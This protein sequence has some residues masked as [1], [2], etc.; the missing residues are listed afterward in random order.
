MRGDDPL[1]QR[2][3]HRRTERGFVAFWMAMVLVV[4]LGICAFAIDLLHTYVVGQEAQNAADAAALGGVVVLPGDPS[5]G[6]ANA[7]AIDLASDNHFATRPGTQV[8]SR[9]TGPNELEVEVQ[10]DVPTWF[11]KI[12]GVDSLHID[13]TARAQYDPP[14]AM[15]SPANNFGDVP[16]DPSNSCN[17]VGFSLPPGGPADCVS[18]PGNDNQKLWA[19]IQGQATTKS[20]GNAFTTNWCGSFFPTDGCQGTSSYGDNLQYDSSH[21]GEYFSIVNEQAHTPIHVY[22]YDASFVDTRNNSGGFT[23]PDAPCGKWLVDSLGNPLPN[24]PGPPAVP[25]PDP[26]MNP[27]CTADRD[28]TGG[29]GGDS[30][31]FDTNYEMR[32][33]DATLSP[34]DNPLY[35]AMSCSPTDVPG[36]N[37]KETPGPPAGPAVLPARQ[38]PYFEKWWQFCEI[39]DSGPA[40]AEW[41][42]HVSSLNSSGK[43][44]NQFSILA[45]HTPQS[46]PANASSAAGLHVFSRERM[47]L[48]STNR[49]A[50]TAAFYLARVLPSPGHQRTLTVEFFDLG[51]TPPLSAP[52]NGTLDI[53]AKNAA[54]PGGVKDCRWAQPPGDSWATAAATGP[55]GA[56]SPPGACT[57]QYDKNGP[58]AWQAQWVTIQV[59]IPSDYTCDTTSYKNCWIQLEITPNRGQVLADATTWTAKMAG[60]P[61]RLVR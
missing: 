1:R 47:P 11:A 40:G 21:P 43:G 60:G 34:F 35:R 17:Q 52:S 42:L 50:G 33:P 26:Y 58:N 45:L 5:G 53:V 8:D 30:L 39:P 44:T 18:V 6:A 10:Q 61:V 41:I 3:E 31:A 57:F 19:Q 51:D 27:Y 28:Q 25:G 12:L 32:A 7:R 13:R 22:V 24:Y 54:F 55:W 37:P 15:G 9:Q 4:L 14:L 56:L 49:S 16:T 59:P 36:D 48:F 29:P 20:S 2:I 46:G 38:D 23:Y